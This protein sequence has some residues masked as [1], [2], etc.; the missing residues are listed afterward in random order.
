MQVFLNTEKLNG[1]NSDW[2]TGSLD[3]QFESHEYN[4]NNYRYRMNYYAT[5]GTLESENTDKN[6]KGVLDKATKAAAEKELEKYFSN[7][8]IMRFD[9]YG[10]MH[11]EV[12]KSDNVA[13]DVLIK[14]F[15]EIEEQNSISG[16]LEQ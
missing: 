16:M 5:N 2:I 3:D 11:I 15:Q 9:E 12:L 7:L 4:F 1:D 10:R 14:T 8:W 13:A 6:L